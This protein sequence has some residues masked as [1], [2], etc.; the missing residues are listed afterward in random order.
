M[1]TLLPMGLALA[2]DRP[3]AR[4]FA[5]EA[6][7]L[8][9]LLGLG[10][11][12]TQLVISGR[13][14][15][16]AAGIGQDNLLQFHRQMGL[17]AWLL[18]LAHPI[19]ILLAEPGFIHYLHP[20]DELL[21]ALAL[22]GI[23][24]ATTLLIATSLWRVG[25]KLQYEWW[26]AIHGVLS[27]FVVSAGLGHALMVDRYTAGW[28]VKIALAVAVGAA[29]LLLIESR[30]LRPWRLKRKPWTVLESEGIEGDATRLVL[31]ADGHK[32]I[33]FA[34]G[35]Y[36]WITLGNTPFSLQQHPFSMN[37]Q[38]HT[39]SRLEFTAKHAGDFTRSLSEVKAGTRAWVEGPY[40]VFT[41]DPASDRDAVFVAGGVGITPIIS[42]LRSCL[43]EKSRKKLLL[44]Y[45]NVD[46]PSVLFWDELE[47]LSSKLNLDVVHVLKEAP[48]DWNGEEGLVDEELLDKYL[49][50]TSG[51]TDY[52]VC[53][54]PPLM[55][56]VESAL[57]TRNVPLQSIH[58]ERFNLV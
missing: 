18:V 23:L 11:L 14:R 26:R 1:L 5:L 58:S 32:G 8:L 7:V 43:A 24:I 12:A 29:L 2:F 34:P 40:G 45:A 10:V 38:A 53:G 19:T 16:F 33:Y 48:E 15:W 22:S 30:L 36:A 46:R 28:P 55:N 31:E 54:P 9:G 17:F 52:F 13:H 42:M 37:S 57:R 39:H 25:M 3:P 20:G 6:G 51:A 41:L 56:V 44:I 47:A 27:L 35:Q 50:N 49:D 21:R 4:T